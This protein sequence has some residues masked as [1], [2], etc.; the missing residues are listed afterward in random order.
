MEKKYY[1]SLEKRTDLLND[2]LKGRGFRLNTYVYFIN[3]VL[4]LAEK[5]VLLKFSEITEYFSQLLYCA[6]FCQICKIVYKSEMLFK[7]G[8]K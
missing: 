1:S 3:P 6:L 5:K 8:K 4:S 7:L 2:T